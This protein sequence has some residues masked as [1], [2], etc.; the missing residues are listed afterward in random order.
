[1]SENNVPVSVMQ[2][3]I[4]FKIIPFGHASIEVKY[5]IAEKEE[6]KFPVY[7]V[8]KTTNPQLIE[9]NFDEYKVPVYSVPKTTV[10]QLI[11]I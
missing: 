8:P 10:P 2:I 11:R 5:H 3:Q 7:Y 9:I 6:E 1:M 4:N